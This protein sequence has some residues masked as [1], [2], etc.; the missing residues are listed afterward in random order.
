MAYLLNMYFYSK[1]YSNR[2]GFAGL[3]IVA[4]APA[5]GYLVGDI[6]GFRCGASL[7][8]NWPRMPH[9]SV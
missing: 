1:A 4:A 3:T 2:A 8:H 7:S 9:P 5:V 6:W